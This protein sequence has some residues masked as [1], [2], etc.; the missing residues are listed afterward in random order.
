MDVAALLWDEQGLFF[1]DTARDYLLTG[2]GLQTWDSPK[3]NL[4]TAVH[5]DPAGGHVA[6]YD[7]GAGPPATV[8]VVATTSRGAARHDAPGRSALTAWCGQKLY[9]VAETAEPY[10]DLIQATGVVERDTS[11]RWPDMLTQLWPQPD[12]LESGLISVWPD[13]QDGYASGGACHKNT[14]LTLTVGQ[15]HPADVV[16]WPTDG[17]PP[18]THP[19]VGPDGR[20]LGPDPATA[21]P[22][23]SSGLVTDWSADDDHVTWCCGD[24]VIR[25]T[26]IHTGRTDNLWDTGAERVRSGRNA[27]AF[28]GPVAHV[29]AATDP[30]DPNSPLRLRSHDLSRHTTQDV[31]TIHSTSP[32]STPTWSYAAS[33]SDPLRH[34]SRAAAAVVPRSSEQPSPPTPAVLKAKCHF[35][36]SD[37][38]AKPSS[39]VSRLLRRRPV[40]ARPGPMAGRE[41]LSAVTDLLPGAGERVLAAVLY[42]PRRAA[43]PRLRRPWLRGHQFRQL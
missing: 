21:S 41:H 9:S 15:G 25:S 42:R 40:S 38:A 37:P 36:G 6:V 28:D 19:V 16:A 2:Q 20:P 39:A 13:G 17:R 30:A 14:I 5:A 23:V 12:N 11:P 32:A 7:P 18:K 26:D 10:L 22:I 34:P 33:P 27:I 1:S 31:L 24:G 43:A 35:I 3:T 29:L 8:Q 4:Q